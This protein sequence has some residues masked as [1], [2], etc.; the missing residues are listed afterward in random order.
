MTASSATLVFAAC[1][2]A[3]IALALAPF[4]A[5]VVP[6]RRPGPAPGVGR[7]RRWLLPMAPRVRPV[8]DVAVARWCE[9]VAAGVRAGRSLTTAVTETDAATPLA[10]R[11]FADVSHALARG[12]PLAEALRSTTDDPSSAIGLLAPVI[13][14][15][16]ELGGSAA[17]LE[18]VAATLLGRAAERDERRASSAQA[19]LSARVLTVLPLGVLAVLLLAEPQIRQVVTTPA[20]LACAV[21]GLAANMVGSLWMRRLIGVGR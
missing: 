9:H 1:V 20:G 6:P 7:P 18:R 17:P 19:R 5:R 12:R 16:A 21:T 11:P 4:R 14:A 10:Q 2:A 15:T 3:A 8:D 13:V